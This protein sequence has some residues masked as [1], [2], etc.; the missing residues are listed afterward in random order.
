[1]GDNTPNLIKD[2][3]HHNLKNFLSY[4]NLS[5]KLRE[6]EKGWGK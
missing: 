1:M 6:K 3:S 4:L 5:Q 2:F